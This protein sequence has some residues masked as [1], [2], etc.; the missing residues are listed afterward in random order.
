MATARALFTCYAS[1]C[2]DCINHQP[3]HSKK[4]K[5]KI[6]N[7]LTD[8]ALKQSFRLLFQPCYLGNN[9]Y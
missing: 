6:D 2:C 1:S 4:K 7:Y 8:I 9:D 5:E 3:F